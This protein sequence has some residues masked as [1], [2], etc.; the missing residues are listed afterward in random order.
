MKTS[1]ITRTFTKALFPAI[2]TVISLVLFIAVYGFEILTAMEPRYFKSLIFALPTV[3]F[4]IVTYLTTNRWVKELPSLVLTSVLVGALSC[5]MLIAFI[6]SVFDA[7]TT[8]TTDVKKYERALRLSSFPESALSNSFPD[9][10]PTDAQD[11]YFSY[12]PAFLQGGEN[13]ALKFK[14]S[15]EAIDR[16]TEE[17]SEKAEWI[18]KEGNLQAGEHGVFGGTVDFFDQSYNWHY[19]ATVYVLS[20]RSNQLGDWNH[21]ELYLVAIKEIS[22]EVLFLAKRW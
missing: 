21:G 13:L 20:S 6:I 3:C 19:N 4:A 2:M 18:G 22:C 16:Y 5:V 11:V 7:A 14:T 8:T 1:R 17:F 15:S 12:N 9:K 10:I